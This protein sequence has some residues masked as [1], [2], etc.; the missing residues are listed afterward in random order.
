M[1]SDVITVYHKN[2]LIE[3]EYLLIKLK[4]DILPRTFFKL[5]FR[6]IVKI[7]YPNDCNIFSS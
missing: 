6:N 4:K 7:I 2:I 5:M 3:V 1:A